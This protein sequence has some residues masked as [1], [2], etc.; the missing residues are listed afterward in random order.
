MVFF[1]DIK[2]STGHIPSKHKTENK[3]SNST[4]KE[5]DLLFADRIHK[6]T[7]LK[8]KRKKAW[9][10]I[11]WASKLRKLR[12]E[13][14]GDTDRIERAITWFE[15]HPRKLPIKSVN[16][17]Y[18]MF[19]EIESKIELGN[20][21]DQTEITPDAKEVAK[22]LRKQ[23]WPKGAA[24]QLPLAIQLSLNNY[25]KLF[26]KIIPLKNKYE[27]LAEE[28]QARMQEFYKLS[29]KQQKDIQ[30]KNRKS[31]LWLG[32]HTYSEEARLRHKY[33]HESMFITYFYNRLPRPL[34]FVEQ[35][36]QAVWR[37]VTNWE[38]WNGDLLYFTFDLN[39]PDFQTFGLTCSYD[40]SNKGSDWDNLMKLLEDKK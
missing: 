20:F 36:Y 13:L 8:L 39:N 14:S 30:S 21:H 33:T 4:I 7:T 12:K 28:Y 16:S 5:I 32:T 40:W 11:S 18:D 22:D 29:K 27:R 2:K 6:V 34:D 15:N 9:S 24:K 35:W 19:G 25:L 31:L 10:K 38:N 23:Y 26:D 1:R 3:V 37:R 17:F